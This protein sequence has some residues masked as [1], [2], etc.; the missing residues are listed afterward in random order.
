MS[1]LDP[2]NGLFWML[3]GN[4]TSNQAVEAKNMPTPRDPFM[5]RYYDVKL[6]SE[7]KI[8]FPNLVVSNSVKSQFLTK[9]FKYI[10]VKQKLKK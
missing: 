10:Y 6:V 2:E 1:K 7:L 5:S 3:G 4:F 8:G 9:Y